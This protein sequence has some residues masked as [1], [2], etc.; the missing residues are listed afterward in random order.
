MTAY[1]HPNGRGT[2]LGEAAHVSADTYL[3]RASVVEGETSLRRSTVVDSNVRDSFLFD[4]SLTGSVAVD[5]R[6]ASSRLLGTSAEGSS[7]TDC[8]AVDSRLR[9]VEVGSRDGRGPSLYMVELEGVVVEGFVRLRGPWSLAG[10][11]R[12]HAGEWKRAPR[13]IRITGENGVVSDVSECTEGRAHISCKCR[14]VSY[15]LERGPAL[16]RRLGWT[17]SQIEECRVF[18]EELKD[19]R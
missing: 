12:I 13:H 8:D 10:H 3:D 2:V 7:V 11:L 9:G 15:W 16:G 17:E 18:F 14:P 6:L 4:T 5:S 19:G 1:L